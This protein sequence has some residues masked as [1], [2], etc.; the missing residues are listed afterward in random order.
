MGHIELVRAG[1]GGRFGR[2]DGAAA[3][4]VRLSGCAD[5]IDALGDDGLGCEAASARSD[6]VRRNFGASDSFVAD[7]AGPDRRGARSDLA[8]AAPAAPDADDPARE[9]PL[10]AREEPRRGDSADSDLTEGDAFRADE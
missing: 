6:G 5:A 8:V 3:A 7:G 9:V 4:E 10:A 2:A 1:G